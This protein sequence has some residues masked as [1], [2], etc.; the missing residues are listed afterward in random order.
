M[1]AHAELQRTTELRFAQLMIS[2]AELQSNFKTLMLSNAELQAN[3]LKLS[4]AE[5]KAESTA[6][7][8]PTANNTQQTHSLATAEHTY[9]ATLN[10]KNN[11]NKQQLRSML[12]NAEL[13]AES[14]A[15]SSAAAEKP[16]ANRTP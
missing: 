6:A 13:K 15:G 3:F 14:T 10:N 8:D 5:L 1:L 12:S 7:E 9:T 4:N 16:T 2:N 11:N